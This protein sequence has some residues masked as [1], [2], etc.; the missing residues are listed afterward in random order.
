MCVHCVGCKTGISLWLHPKEYRQLWSRLTGGPGGP[1]HPPPSSVVPGMKEA[2][3]GDSPQ[4]GGGIWVL[5]E[6]GR[7]FLFPGSGRSSLK[8]GKGPDDL[9]IMQSTCGQPVWQPCAGLRAPSPSGWAHRRG[10]SRHRCLV[11]ILSPVPLPC[12]A[13]ATGCQVSQFL[14]CPPALPPPGPEGSLA[15][16]GLR[17]RPHPW[18]PSRWLWNP[19]PPPPLCL[20]H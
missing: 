16:R 11:I 9:E 1:R 19:C 2:M 8:A 13:A 7:S 4:Q 3:C 10:A 6:L 15:V 12:G 18:P 17:A 5:S 20:G 14:H